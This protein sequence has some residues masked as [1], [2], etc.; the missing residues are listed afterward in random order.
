MK[1]AL[2]NAADKVRL[3]GDKIWNLAMRALEAPSDIGDRIDGLA[4]GTDRKIR[5]LSEKA[6]PFVSE[7]AFAFYGR[8]LRYLGKFFNSCRFRRFE[9]YL[10]AGTGEPD[11]TGELIGFLYLVLPQASGNYEIQP[12]FYQKV[13]RTDTRLK[14]HVR[15]NHALMLLLRLL[16]DKEFRRL[17]RV[18]RHKKDRRKTASGK[19]RNRKRKLR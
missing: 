3:L 13:F 1:Q 9:G 12:D 4:D 8:A 6:G 18:I 2:R 11:R 7:D 16:K 19:R 14:G 15:L 17:L 5:K 10:L